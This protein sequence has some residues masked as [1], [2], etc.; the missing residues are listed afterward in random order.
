VT[1]PVEDMVA[2]V[3]AHYERRAVA[4]STRTDTATNEPSGRSRYRPESLQV[5]FGER[6]R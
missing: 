2:A 6:V 1:A 4:A 5:L 3:L